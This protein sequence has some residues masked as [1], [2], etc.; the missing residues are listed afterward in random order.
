MDSFNIID[1]LN[2]QPGDLDIIKKELG[3]INGIFQVAVNK[4]ETIDNR[5]DKYVE[6]SSAMAYYLE[7]YAFE[8]EIETMAKLYS[9]DPNRLKNIRNSILD[10]LNDKK[11]ME[12]IESIIANS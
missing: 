9:E 5:S 3:R 12:K 6:L 1:N 7:N 2:D 4:L 10:A 8:R 11:L